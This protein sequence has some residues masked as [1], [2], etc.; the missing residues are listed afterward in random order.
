MTVNAAFVFEQTLGHATHYQ[1]LRQTACEFRS[2]QPTWLPIEYE[3]P[4]ALR[5]LPVAGGNW[6]IRASWLARRALSGA[7]R[8]CPHQA[9][10][11]HTQVTALFST[12]LMRRIPSIVSLD[13][14]PANFDSVGRYYGHLPA[15]GTLLDRGKHRWARSIFHSARALVAWSDWAKQS[16]V[17]DYQVPDDRVRVIAP[18]AAPGYFEIGQRREAVAPKDRGLPAE[19][20]K[21]LFVGGDFRRKGGPL[22]LELM[23]GPLGGRC[24][25]DVVTSSP[26]EVG[27]NVHVHFGLGPNDPALLRLF[28]RAD[29]FV[30]PSLAE[31]LAIVL[32]E[33]T[34]AGLPVMATNV[35]ALREAVTDGQSGFLF[36][37]GDLS[38]LACA[39]AA[40]AD[41]PTR[42]ATMGR[43]SF[44]LANERFDARTN[45]RALL[46]LVAEIAD[47]T[48]QS[49][50]AA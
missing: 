11:F 39:I 42:R 26:V 16:L 41:D 35:G 18:G 8:N 23:R 38:A 43:E 22:L 2:V 5:M 45:G 10:V 50:R 7:L 46:Q 17:H 48:D 1:N 27:P 47:R 28:E 32:M 3:R 20:L 36:R 49:G 21:L 40:L 25:L 6:S 13:A 24:E 14:T 12:G 4:T 31:C 19:R 29:I 33:A 34:A 37:A 44:R 15:R 30:L 9:L